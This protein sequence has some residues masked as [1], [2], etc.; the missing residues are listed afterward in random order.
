MT[1]KASL[2]VLFSSVDIKTALKRMFIQIKSIQLQSISL[3]HSKL[4]LHVFQSHFS[5][6]SIHVLLRAA[7]SDLQFHTKSIMNHN[8]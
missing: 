1:S 6:H 5:I 3:I 4:P 2:F 7:F 8:S